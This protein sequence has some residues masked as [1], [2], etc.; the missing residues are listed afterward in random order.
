MREKTTDTLPFSSLEEATGE[1]PYNMLNDY[2]FRAVLQSNNKVLCGLIRALLHLPEDVP[3]KAEI[4]NP[5]LL[6]EAIEDKEFRLDINVIINDTVRLN[7]EMQVANVINWKNRSLSYICRSFDQVSRGA[8]YDEIQP[9]IHIGFLNFTL[10]KEAPQFYAKYKF[11]NTTNHMVYSDDLELCVLDLTQIK[12]ATE[13]DKAYQID[14][15]AALFKSKTWE[16]MKMLAEKNEYLKETAQTVF[17]MSAEELVLKRCRDREDYYA[18]IRSY[19]KALKKR[20]EVIEEQSEQLKEQ[21][22]QIK[23]QSAQLKEQSTQIKELNAVVKECFMQIE[24]MK[25]QI[26]DLKDVK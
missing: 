26:S 23:E 6:G 1:I 4:T 16:E 9:V 10:F 21:S 8:E 12:L 22:E 2:M 18:D 11:M 17:R 14:Y 7:L 20:D 24:D 25:R 19:K 13:E 5:V 15:W 3:L